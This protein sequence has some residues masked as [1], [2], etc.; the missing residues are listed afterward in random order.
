MSRLNLRSVEA[1]LRAVEHLETGRG[2]R[3]M[4]LDLLLADLSG[5]QRQQTG[6]GLDWRLV[7]LQSKCAWCRLE[8]RS[9]DGALLGESAR[10]VERHGRCAHAPFCTQESQHMARF[11]VG[12]VACPLQ[13]CLVALDRVT[14]SV[15]QHTA[16]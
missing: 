11:L 7:K 12:A 1:V 9:H 2:A 8:F 16:I 15:R 6:D 13:L 14:N 3:Q 10:D 5:W 4:R